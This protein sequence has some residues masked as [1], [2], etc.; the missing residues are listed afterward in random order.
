[1][2]STKFQ[3]IWESGFRGDFLEINQLEEKNG[4]C[5]LKFGRKHIWK[6]LYKDWSFCPDLL[7]NIATTGHS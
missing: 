7:T 6:V 1:M 3:I 2:L 4:L 5:E